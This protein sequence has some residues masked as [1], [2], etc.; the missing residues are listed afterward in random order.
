MT[1]PL[2]SEADLETVPCEGCGRSAPVRTMA[3]GDGLSVAVCRCGLG[4]L[5]PRP[6]AHAIS[7]IYEIKGRPRFNP[8][9]AHMSGLDMAEQHA[10]FD[11]LSRAL[12]EAFWPGPLTLVLPL[13][14]ESPI[15]ALCT[16]G[17]PTVGVRVP[18]GFTGRLIAAYGRPLAAPSAN[19]SGRISP[20]SA[21]HVLADLGDRIGLIL[22]GGE[23]VSIDG[24]HSPF[25]SRPAELAEVLVACTTS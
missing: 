20:T 11:P 1:A 15:H 18:E 19:T 8:L 7:R 12:A 2:W 5:N 14:P 10:E 24:S 22:D 16:A 25:L 6:K 17:L 3:R 23:P 9:I 13:R 21:Q 4:Y